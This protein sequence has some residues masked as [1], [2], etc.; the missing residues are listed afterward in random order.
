MIQIRLISADISVEI[1]RVFY[2]AIREGAP[3]YSKEQRAAWAPEPR[4]G[5]AWV[6]RLA[7]QQIWGAFDGQHL[8]GFMTLENQSYVDFAYILAEYQ[9]QGLFPRLFE[10]VEQA[11]RIAGTTTMKT[12]ASL[13]ARRA[14]E[15][16]GFDVVTP[17]TVELNGQSFKRFEMA[18]QLVD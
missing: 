6:K 11:A 17:E 7:A 12:H 1:G 8:I 13:M 14:F 4:K 2:Q 15:K 10:P 9:G 16:V 18:K 3:A 5:E